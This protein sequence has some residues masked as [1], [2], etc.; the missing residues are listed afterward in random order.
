MNPLNNGARP[1]QVITLRQLSRMRPLGH[2]G[3]QRCIA[4]RKKYLRNLDRFELAAPTVGVRD[5]DGQ[6]VTAAG[7][8]AR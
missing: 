5:H 3:H 7:L 6:T 1:E 8:F 2:A 4:R